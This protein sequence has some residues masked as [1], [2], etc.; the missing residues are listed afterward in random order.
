MH[1]IFRRR[2][3]L[4]NELLDGAFLKYT[5]ACYIVALHQYTVADCNLLLCTNDP[6]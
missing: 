4:F 2:W 1:L 6:N 3:S 5:K